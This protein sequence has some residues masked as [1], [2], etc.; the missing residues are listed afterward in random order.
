MTLGNSSYQQGLSARCN[1]F[2]TKSGY[3]CQLDKVPFLK[4]HSASSTLSAEMCRALCLARA[5]SG[6]LCCWYKPSVGCYMKKGAASAPTA[7]GSGGSYSTMCIPGA[8]GVQR[9]APAPLNMQGRDTKHTSATHALA[10]HSWQS[11]EYL[12]ALRQ[13]SPQPARL[14]LACAGLPA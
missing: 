5:K 14:R 10:L 9:P 11:Q 7:G 3:T 13:A 1:A 2:P 4:L 8:S 6:V 12:S